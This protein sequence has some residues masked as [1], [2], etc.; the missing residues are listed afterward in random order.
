MKTSHEIL[1]SEIKERLR[2]QFESID[3]L[4]NKAGIALGVSGAILI[5]LISSNWFTNL[6]YFTSLIVI[7]PIIV[8]ILFFIITIFVRIYSKDPDPTNLIKGYQNKSKDDTL[9]Q[10]IRNFES[11]FKKN[12][13]PLENKR[14]YLNNGFIATGI[15]IIIIC[16]VF[17]FS[18]KVQYDTSIYKFNRQGVN[19]YGR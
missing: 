19:Y 6:C 8:A 1:F 5:G 2:D 13:Q 4:D 7:I 15:A 9:G 10:L 12:V 17:I 16:S 14:N 18:K 11:S 3:S